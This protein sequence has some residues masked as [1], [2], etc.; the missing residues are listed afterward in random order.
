MILTYAKNRTS[1][2]EQVRSSGNIS[3]LNSGGVR[4]ER[5]IMVKITNG[6]DQSDPEGVWKWPL[7]LQ[8]AC[9]ET[10]PIWTESAVDFV[11]PTQINSWG[12]YGLYRGPNYSAP[13]SF[14]LTRQ[15]QPLPHYFLT[16]LSVFSLCMT[17][18]GICT[19]STRTYQL[20]LKRRL[21]S[22]FPQAATTEGLK[23]ES[24]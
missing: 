23:F 7:N 8:G 20:S 17:R 4:F 14:P 15:L 19:I 13:P 16:Y 21:F 22:S 6:P 5:F 9:F 3:D 10:W 11:A 1:V 18:S 24:P 2:T 12:V